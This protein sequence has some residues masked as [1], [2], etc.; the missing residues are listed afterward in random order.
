M[1]ADIATPGLGAILLMSGM[2][3]VRSLL[4]RPRQKDEYR[5]DD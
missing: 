3:A 4:K 1:P 2:A 5:G